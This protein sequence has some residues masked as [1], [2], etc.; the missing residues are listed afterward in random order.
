[1]QLLNSPFEFNRRSFL[2]LAGGGIG[3]LALNH[4]L[5]AETSHSP[6]P[7]VRA[8]QKLNHRPKAKSVILLFQNGGPSQ[9]DLFDPKPELTRSHGK[10]YPGEVE[11]HFHTQVRNMMASPFRF[12]RY[13][14]TGME[15]TELLPFTGGIADDITLIR[16]MST[17]SVDHEQA[18]RLIHSGS[19]V[20]PKASLGSW[21]VYGLG[22]ERD[23]VPAFV[24]LTDPDGLPID[25]VKNWT[26]GF[27]P[28]E[29]QGT[30]FRAKGTPVLN[31]QPPASISV[32]AR[33]NQ[34][35]FLRKLNQAHSNRFVNGS[36]LAARLNNFELAARMQIAVPEMLDIAQETAETQQLYGIDQSPT[37]DYG[38]RCLLARRL[39]EQGVRFVGVYLNGQPWDTHSK[40]AESL[41]SLCTRT[42]R[43][44]AA[45]VH[46]L[47]R[48]GLLDET[49]VIWAG[50]FGRLPV[51][52][53]P[54]GRDHNRHA[55]SLW[56]AG[57]GFKA[58]YVHGATDEFGYKSVE[59]VV[60]IHDLHATLLH[61]LGLDHERLTFPHDGRDDSLTDSPVTG[62]SPAFAL[63]S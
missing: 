10:P 3:C 20:I 22:A 52:Q 45:L 60:S 1:M 49:I 63:L 35:D 2:S 34:L 27:L 21:V 36:E 29:F 46:D 58:G 50:E 55:F 53:G 17:L 43:P 56:I 4:L 7:H 6:S 38:R 42:D 8:T 62:A 39:V 19:T 41:K 9:M 51:S 18:L 54:D 37:Q 40:N 32:A 26:S 31:L 23:D 24:V 44:S 48:R 11:A 47:K 15:M 59:Q 25:G 28:A 30:T 61:A 57:G 16:S 33:Q 5:Q 14:R 13:G 12:Q